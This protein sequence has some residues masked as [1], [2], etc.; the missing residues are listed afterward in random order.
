M[1]VVT[2]ETKDQKIKKQDRDD[3]L[4]IIDTFRERFVNG[5]VNEFVIS[6]LDEEGEAEIYIASQDLVGAVGMFELGKEALLSQY[7]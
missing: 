2:L 7:R 6:C 4:E 1:K 5:E 3:F